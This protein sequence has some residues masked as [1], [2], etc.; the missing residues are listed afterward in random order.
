MTEKSEL[1]GMVEWARQP[2]VLTIS[3]VDVIAVFDGLEGDELDALG[4]LVEALREG[5]RH[6]GAL[7]VASDPRD[8]GAE[9]DKELIDFPLWLSFEALRRRRKAQEG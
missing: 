2:H 5:K 8:Y 9:A 3:S 1:R 7:D 6:F 4:L